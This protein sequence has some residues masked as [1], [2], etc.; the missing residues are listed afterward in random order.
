LGD[1]SVLGK[2]YIA[3]R[4]T[5]PNFKFKE[6]EGKNGGIVSLQTVVIRLA[7]DSRYVVA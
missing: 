5:E 2:G 7:G 3:K 1:E 6:S 4:T